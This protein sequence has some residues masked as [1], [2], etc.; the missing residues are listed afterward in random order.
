M[1]V[2]FKF[3]DKAEQ[4]AVQEKAKQRKAKKRENDLKLQ[5]LP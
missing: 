5:W 3:K 2:R 4:N 1:A